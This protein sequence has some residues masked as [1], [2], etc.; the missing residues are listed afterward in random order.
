V[1]NE[2]ERRESGG[3]SLYVLGDGEPPLGD[4]T[5]E[6]HHDGE[7]QEEFFFCYQSERDVFFFLLGAERGDNCEVAERTS[8][9]ANIMRF[10]AIN[11]E[12]MW[13]L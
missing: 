6:N 11:R 1:E 9:R 10:F 3:E 8:E 13:G 4:D 5:G 12:N 7:S 2:R